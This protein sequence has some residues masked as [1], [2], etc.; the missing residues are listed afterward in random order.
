[1]KLSSLLYEKVLL[2]AGSMTIQAGPHGSSSWRHQSRPDQR[3][4]W[5]TPRGRALSQSVPF[6]VSIAAESA[7]GVAASGPY[8]RVLASETSIAWQPSLEPFLEEI[9]QCDWVEYGY[10]GPMAPE[11]GQLEDRWK[12]IDDANGVLERLVP[13]RFVRSQLVKDIGHDLAVG[14]SGGWDVSVGR[15]HGRV[16]GARFA[17]DATVQA[18]GVALPVLVPRVGHLQWSDIARIR[19]LK[20]IQRFREVLRE[21][22]VEAFE[23][24]RSG[25]DLET[26][27]HQAYTRRVA[28]A[29]EKVHGLRSIGAMGVAELLVGASAG[30]ATTGLSVLGPLT[31]A[32]ASAVVT[33][34]YHAGRNLRERRQRAWLGVMDAIC[35]A[36][37]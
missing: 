12:R 15:F 4:G 5:Q 37:G 27:M 30:Y 23:V 34:V 33:T 2:E 11:F 7:P 32:G 8:H 22:E 31:G 3:V 1:M 6:S 19:K 26:A 36:S 17:G 10:P 13:E 14:A 21:V 16:I 25:A 28:S 9:A 24:A 20:A 29:S 35:T 18:R